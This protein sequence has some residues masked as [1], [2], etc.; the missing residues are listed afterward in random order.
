[1][2]LNMEKRLVDNYLKSGEC[3]DE[4]IRIKLSNLHITKKKK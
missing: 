1:M 2:D 3:K 4:N